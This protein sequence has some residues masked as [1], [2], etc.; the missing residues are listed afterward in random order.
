MG[1]QVDTVVQQL[2]DGVSPVRMQA[3][4]AVFSNLF[5]DS[6]S[7]DEWAAASYLAGQLRSAGVE[8][9]LLA[10]DS[11]IS[12]PLKGRLTILGAQGE[13]GH[14]IPVRT[15][16]FGART[17][18]G[19]FEAELVFVPFHAP[20]GGSSIFAHREIAA[21][22]TGL[23]VTG[24]VVI[25][26]DGG[27]DG[28]FRAQER[29]A[30]GHIHIWPSDE[31]VIHEMICTSVWGTPV[32]ESAGRRPTIPVLGMTHADGEE[33]AAQLRVETVRARLEANVD[34]AWRRVPLVVAE[35][36]SPVSDD[37][38]LIGGHID[39]WYEG[40][41]DN[42]TGDVAMLEMARVVAAVKP[43]LRRGVRFAWWPGHS[44]GR[45][46]GSTWYADEFF[47]ELRQHAV[48]YLNI[49]SP[50]VRGAVDWEC[51][52]NTAEVQHITAARVRE[53]SDQ[54]PYMGRPFRAADQSF[55][56]IGL[57]SLMAY[58]NLPLDHP[59]RAT[60]G[61]CGGAYWWHSP[62]DTLDKA[63]VNLLAEEVG[64]YLAMTYDL[65][66]PE[67]LPYR[68][69]PAAQDVIDQLTVYQTAAGDRLDLQPV[70][71]SAEQLKQAAALLAATAP[72]NLDA[73][74]QGLKRL[75]QIVN[76]ALYTINGPYEMDPALQLSILPGLAPVQQLATLEPS[77]DAYGFLRTKL[78]RQRN[79]IQDALREATAL[80]TTLA[81]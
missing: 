3:D 6:G 24:K 51:R 18:P 73:R 43:Q 58:R 15:R 4:L 46:S 54:E 57:P 65:C 21:D 42:A 34:T 77:S 69:A 22:Y 17:G 12:W 36:K 32:P 70:I 76:S 60:V 9:E 7:E 20:K 80:A 64:V 47:A 37:F 45:Y 25:T 55:L 62:E 14:Q 74:N 49:D 28:V 63:D 81:Q 35:I 68:L 26:A 78:V 10:F 31:Q 75:V 13:A 2:R 33:L 67:L 27:P 30:A 61:G 11:L 8:A 40:I 44:T 72:A 41:T 39:S 56:G 48:G 16:A 38:L 29:G 50:G 19:G 53:V 52:F 1:H 79:R 66:A 59:D 23:D 71:D 5:R